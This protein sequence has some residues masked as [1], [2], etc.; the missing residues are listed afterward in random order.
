MPTPVPHPSGSRHRQ[1]HLHSA[2]RHRSTLN[3]SGPSSN[4]GTTL[5]IWQATGGT[6][7]IFAIGTN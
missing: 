7:T 3:V 4:N 5:Q 6:N 1:L 2:V